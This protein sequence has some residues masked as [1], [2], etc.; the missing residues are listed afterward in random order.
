MLHS[1]CIGDSVAGSVV[2]VVGW[3]GVLVVNLVVG[4]LDSVV[5]V[6]VGLVVVVVW[7]VV[8]IVVVVWMKF[9]FGS[10]NSNLACHLPDSSKSRLLKS[11]M[12][13]TFIWL[14]L[15]RLGRG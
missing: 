11:E 12:N 15:V 5:V 4:I 1:T 6:I 10:T 2:V 9:G 14:D 7:V 13:L 8:E 3:V